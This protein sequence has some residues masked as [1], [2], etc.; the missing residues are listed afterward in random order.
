MPN[1][2]DLFRGQVRDKILGGGPCQSQGSGVLIFH[3]PQGIPHH[4]ARIVVPPALYLFANVSGKTIRNRHVHLIHHLPL[5]RWVDRFHMSNL[6]VN[7][8]HVNL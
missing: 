6:P 2:F 3:T 7:P 4:L 8:V 5:W 1:A